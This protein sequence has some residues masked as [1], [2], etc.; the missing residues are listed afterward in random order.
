[1]PLKTFNCVNCI[2]QRAFLISSLFPAEPQGLSNE[3]KDVSVLQDGLGGGFPCAVPTTG[4]HPDHQGLTLHGAT[5]HPILQGSTIL[6]GVQRHHT[7]IVIC[8]Q[9]KNSRV[10]RTRVGWLRQ[11]MERRVPG[12]RVRK[13]V[14]K[15]LHT[16]REQRESRSDLFEI[17]NKLE[18]DFW[19]YWNPWNKMYLK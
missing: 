12:Q 19:Y 3:W 2:L 5:A 18:I 16:I 8:C 17:N 9:K 14:R 4:V 11:I 1:M 10:G 6:Q 15:L 13:N 7:I